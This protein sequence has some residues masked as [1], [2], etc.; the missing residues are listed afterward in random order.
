MESVLRVDQEHLVRELLKMHASIA[1]I[2][3][4][5]SRKLGGSSQN[6]LSRLYFAVGN[7]R[8]R[9]T[10]LFSVL[11]DLHTRIEY[12]FYVPTSEGD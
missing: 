12:F 9:L 1:E 11:E 4:M 5:A 8:A 2:K 10:E 6:E 3:S 7:T